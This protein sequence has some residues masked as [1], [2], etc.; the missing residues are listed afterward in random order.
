MRKGLEEATLGDSG[1]LVLKGVEIVSVT[2]FGGRKDILENVYLTVL[3]GG[4]ECVN[5]GDGVREAV[6]GFTPEVFSE[7]A[8]AFLGDFNL[9]IFEDVALEDLKAFTLDVFGRLRLGGPCGKA[10]EGAD[11]AVSSQAALGICVVGG[12]WLV[13]LGCRAATLEPMLDDLNLALAER[14]KGGSGGLAAAAILTL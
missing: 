8:L 7:A 9:E 10:T 12:V 1:R 13:P 2:G 6:V 11:L 4:V 3:G 5:C 14:T